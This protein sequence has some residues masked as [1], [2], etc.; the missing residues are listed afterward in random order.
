MSRY[1]EYFTKLKAKYIKIGSVQIDE[2]STDGTFAGNSDTAVPT[3]KAV[4]TY[5][6]GVV[7]GSVASAFIEDPDGA[8]TGDMIYYDGTDWVLVTTVGAGDM[9]YFDGTD[10][11]VSSPAGAGDIYYFDGTDVVTVS[12]AAT[13]DMTYFDGA[14]WQ[15]VSPSAGDILYFNGTAVTGVTP[16][17]SGDMIYY[18]GA[19]WNVITIGSSGDV[20]TVN[21]SG[22]P[23]F[24]TP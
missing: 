14:D 5:V 10:W 6:A 15:V 18:D 8:A 1:S 13:G 9:L 21:A 24:V 22:I 11:Q 7:S 20:L 16:A 4:K 23:E 12:P 3:E 19:A 17:A 2:I